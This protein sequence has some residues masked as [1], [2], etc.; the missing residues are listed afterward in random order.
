MQLKYDLGSYLHGRKSTD[1]HKLIYTQELGQE[2]CA[3]E[4]FLRG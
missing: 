2:F 3:K 1:L 4:G